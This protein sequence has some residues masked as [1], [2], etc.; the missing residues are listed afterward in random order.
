MVV[1]HFYSSFRVQTFVKGES[2]V[3]IVMLIAMANI[4][5]SLVIGLF[6]FFFYERDGFFLYKKKT[7]N[8]KK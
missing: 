7:S 6:S 8:K 1:F 4:L 5:L 3:G 2:E